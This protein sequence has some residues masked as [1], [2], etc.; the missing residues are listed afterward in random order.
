MNKEVS[1]VNLGF[2]EFIFIKRLQGQIK[3]FWKGGSFV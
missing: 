1:G 2:L 3:D